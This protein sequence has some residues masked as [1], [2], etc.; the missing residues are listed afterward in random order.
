MK[1]A[2]DSLVVVMRRRWVLTLLRKP[3]STLA[4]LTDRERGMRMGFSRITVGWDQKEASAR[5]V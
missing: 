4:A 3:L 5:A 2:D 1:A